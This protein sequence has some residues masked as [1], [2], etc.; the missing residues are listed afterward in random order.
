[1]E[2]LKISLFEPLQI[3]L[4]DEIISDFRMQKVVALL[5]YLAAEPET[6]HR[7]ETF[8]TLLWPGMPDASVR[9]NL[10]QVLFL[11]KK[12]IPDFDVEDS[13][14]PILITKRNQ[15]Y[16]AVLESHERR[17]G[18]YKNILADTIQ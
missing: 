18:T 2:Q 10:R 11:L 7:R 15:S 8:M 17:N 13:A 12:A 14:V 1:M 16:G 5:V 6:A 3:R 4:N 9:T